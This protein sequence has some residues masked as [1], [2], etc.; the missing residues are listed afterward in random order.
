MIMQKVITIATIAGVS[1]SSNFTIIDYPEV[2]ALLAEGY[3]IKEVHQSAPNQN[4]FGVMITIVLEKQK[5]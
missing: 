1:Q 4:V 5:Q 2:D 3:S